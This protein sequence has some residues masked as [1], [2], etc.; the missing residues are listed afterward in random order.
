MSRPPVPAVFTLP[1]RA[2]GAARVVRGARAFG[3]GGCGGLSREAAAAD[4]AAVTVTATA[5]CR[6][7]PARRSARLSTAPSAAP[8]LGA[9]HGSCGGHGSCGR[10]AVGLGVAVAVRRLGLELRLGRDHQGVVGLEVPGLALDVRL[11]CSLAARRRPAGRSE[12][13]DG[14]KS[15]SWASQSVVLLAPGRRG[16]GLAPRRCCGRGTAGTWPVGASFQCGRSGCSSTTGP[17]T[18]RT[19]SPAGSAPMMRTRPEW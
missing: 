14:S 1:V 9:R 17:V 6:R 3:S 2:R 16:D 4:A 19:A 8:S 10:Q 12:S 15:S 13:I 11:G 5:A 18:S 7:R